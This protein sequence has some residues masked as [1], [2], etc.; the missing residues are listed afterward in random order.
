M[1]L[2][3][4]LSACAAPAAPANNAE[5]PS[6]PLSLDI[7]HL[8]NTNS[9]VIPHDVM[10]HLAG[11]DIL[12]VA[13]GWSVLASAVQDIRSREKNVM[14]LHAGDMIEGTIWTTAFGGMADVDAMNLLQFDAMAL[15]SHELSKGPVE[16]AALINRAKFPVLAANMDV[17]REP[18]L[19]GKIKPYI[20]MEFQGQKIAV[21]GLITPDTELLSYPGR[22]ITFLPPAEIADKLIRELSRQGINKFIV[23]S[24]LGYDADVKLA[25]TVPGIDIIVGGHLGTF[26]GGPEFAQ[27]GLKPEKPYPVEMTGPAGDKVLIVHAWQNNQ[28]LGQIRLDFDGSGK[29]QSYNAQPFIFT[30]ASFK[31]EESSGWYH[32][33]SCMPQ[34]SSIMETIARNP[35]I[36]IYWNSPDMDALLQPYVNQITSELNSVVGVAEENLLRGP[37]KGPG[38]LAADAFL[39]SAQKV[40]P[41]VQMA[42]YDSY[43]I[44]AD[45]YKGNILKNDIEMVLPLR[46]T[47]ATVTISGKL[48]KQLLEMEIDWH[49]R[50]GMP[51]PCFEI[52]GLKMMIDMTRKSGERVS[53][54]RVRAPDGTYKDM[55]VASEY[56]VVT[57]DYMVD[58]GLDEYVYS[59]QWLGPVAEGLK[60]WARDFVKYKNLGIRD[61]DA[62]S[63]YF[64][65]QKGIKNVIEQRTA[66][67]EPAS[68]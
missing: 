25:A 65:V 28:L 44:R 32:L 14:L 2:L 43:G 59:T 13:G 51:P 1:L 3:I 22:N 48:L 7:L 30:M 47:L 55:D 20:I 24:H 37:D 5:V 36:K 46:Q 39:W 35:E 64:K 66:F 26:M 33:C 18:L 12:A 53:G 40:D 41:S 52:A 10:L 11:T 61:V 21:I 38:P 6:Q 67:I 58:R 4:L 17:S 68:K 45:I 29:I 62:M 23:L 16:A 54:L 27:I 8:N 42:I 34:Y 19:S 56:T 9:Y 31:L 50:L 15:G 49:I 57:T 60:S 63:D